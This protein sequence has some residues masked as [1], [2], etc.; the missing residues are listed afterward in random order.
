MSHQVKST[1]RQLAWLHIVASPILPARHLCRISY[2]QI[3]PISKK[4]NAGTSWN[5]LIIPLKEHRVLEPSSTPLKK[6]VTMRKFLWESI[7]ISRGNS[8]DEY[9][10]G[11]YVFAQ[12][13]VTSSWETKLC[14]TQHFMLETRSVMECNR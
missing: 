11:K 9:G 2:F 6:K 12:I 8:E 10:A 14:A 3:S 13:L 5:K 4:R 7:H 1:S